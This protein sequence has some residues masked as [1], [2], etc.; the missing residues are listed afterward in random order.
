MHA[1]PS[2]AGLRCVSAANRDVPAQKC[3]WMHFIIIIKYKLADHLTIYFP[4]DHNQTNPV[5][6]G[7]G[8][9]GWKIS[10]EVERDAV[11]QKWAKLCFYPFTG[12]K[13]L[14]RRQ[15]PVK[16]N[17]GFSHSVTLVRPLWFLT[18]YGVTDFFKKLTKS[19]DILRKRHPHV[20]NFN[21]IGVT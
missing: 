5:E 21:N 20:D 2:K 19:L 3:F 12:A 7:A 15:W 16:K 11:D 18:I 8:Q 6:S 10:M 9:W 14:Y 4:L 13:S 1:L 17:S